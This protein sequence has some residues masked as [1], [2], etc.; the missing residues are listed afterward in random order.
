MIKII[1]AHKRA[2]FFTKQR[3]INTEREKM[4]HFAN[5]TYKYDFKGMI[6]AQKDTN[7]MR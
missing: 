6:Y 3:E 1:G 5:K 4:K 7:K 2:V